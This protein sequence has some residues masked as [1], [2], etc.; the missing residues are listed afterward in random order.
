MLWFDFRYLDFFSQ[1]IE[2][3]K[4][5]SF[6]TPQSKVQVWFTALVMDFVIVVVVVVV[7]VV[8]CLSCSAALISVYTPQCYLHFL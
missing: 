1:V 4:V 8:V 6:F 5:Y 2:Q 3:A 7:V